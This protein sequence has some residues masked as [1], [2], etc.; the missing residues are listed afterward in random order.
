MIAFVIPTLLVLLMRNVA[1]L[2]NTTAEATK[3]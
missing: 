2:A 1:A 3:P